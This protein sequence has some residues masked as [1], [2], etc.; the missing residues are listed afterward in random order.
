MTAEMVRASVLVLAYRSADT[1]G[2]AVES[3][4]RQSVAELEVIIVGDG[5]DTATRSVAEGLAQHEARVRFLDLPKGENRGERNRDTGVRAARS[6]AIVYLADDD[7][8]LPSHVGNMLDLLRDHGFAQSRNGFIAPGDVL[9]LF[10]ADLSDPANIEWHLRDPPRNAVSITG[11]AHSRALYLDLDRG[12]DVTPAGLWTDLHMW[13]AFFRHP[14]F[15]GATHTELTTLQFPASAYVDQ[16]R[17]ETVAMMTRWQ[18][19]SRRPDVAAA[20]AELVEEAERRTLVRLTMTATNNAFA[21]AAM[22]RS[23]RR[24]VLA[25]KLAARNAVRE[26]DAMRAT[27]SWRITAPLRWARSLRRGGPPHGVSDA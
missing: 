2:F 1:L 6:D 14:R 26:R 17:D 13:R 27:V 24:R 7:M 9:E 10:P 11:T 21:L 5:V 25:A 20:V 18:H 4:L 16:T 8:L 19:F 3:A 15:S 22:R 23:A 12:W